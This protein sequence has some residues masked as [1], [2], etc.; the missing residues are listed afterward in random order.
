MAP[1]QYREYLEQQYAYSAYT[2]ATES[3]AIFVMNNEKNEDLL[4]EDFTTMKSMLFGMVKYNS[5]SFTNEFIDNYSVRNNFMPDNITYYNNMTE[6]LAALEK[7]DIEAAVAN[8][9]FTN[10]KYK[11]VGRFSP[12]T[13]YYIMQKNNNGLKDELD[14]AMSS[15]V[16]SDPGYQAEVMSDYF[17]FYGISSF[18]YDE[19]EYIIT[20]PTIKVGYQVNHSP[21]SYTDENGEFAGIS[22]RI[23]DSIAENCGIT[24][25]YVALPANGVDAAFLKSNGINVLCNVEYKASFQADAIGSIAHFP[26]DKKALLVIDVDDFKTV[27]DKYGHLLGDKVL[28]ILQIHW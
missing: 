27:N 14:E 21:L 11:M 20:L 26:E 9:L 19:E 17:R 3:A 7:G 12:M 10:E 15:I 5:S 8:I 4:Y 25:E 23:M 18:T 13:S 24:F 16:L 28:K 22:R 2:M 1:V 6:L